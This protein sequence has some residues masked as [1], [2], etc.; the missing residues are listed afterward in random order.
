MLAAST[1]PLI[2]AEKNW[3]GVI[4][5]T[6]RRITRIVPN[7]SGTSSILNHLQMKNAMFDLLIA[8]L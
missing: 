8:A 5:A 7:R 4:A 3:L 1:A 6:A 2:I